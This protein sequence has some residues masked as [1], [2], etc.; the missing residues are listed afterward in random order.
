M[1]LDWLGLAV[2]ASGI[3]V[4]ILHRRSLR[5]PIDIW[6]LIYVAFTVASAIVHRAEFST[7]PSIGERNA[8]WQPAFQVVVL[9]V[10]FYGA[11]VLLA[12]PRRLALLIIT[13]VVAISIF[14]VQA[15]ADHARVGLNQRLL[16]YASLWRWSGYTPLG[17]L[18][19]LGFALVVPA[20]A[21]ART[22]VGFTAAVLLALVFAL[23]TVGVYSRA[24]MVCVALTYVAAA[25][26]EFRRLGTKRLAAGGV[27]MLAAALVAIAASGFS[28]SELV[29]FLRGDF[30]SYSGAHYVYVSRFLVWRRVSE[31]VGGH[32]WMGVGPGNY[33]DAMARLA[34]SV[35]DERFVRDWY[36]IHAHNTIL[37]V[38]AESGVIA[39]FAFLVM[40]LTLIWQRAAMCGRDTRGVL[41][42]IVF[43]ALVVLFL[44]SIAEHLLS[45]L[46]VATRM[47][48]ILWTWF[49]AS[50]AAARVEE[51]R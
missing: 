45:N 31:L 19:A 47:N 4:G 11:S 46:F 28:V 51:D 42:F 26:V 8:P 7:V 48:F 39:A 41:A 27:V 25:V 21:I 43:N 32:L 2:G 1:P 15:V 40:W 22:T 17:L 12:T 5:T 29:S 3:V 34:A 16:D 37:H 18:F 36:T 50:V 44:L 33:M 24:S 49:A 6:L 30:Y 9:A 20:I 38:A 23:E 35:G 10:Y 14:G 13:F